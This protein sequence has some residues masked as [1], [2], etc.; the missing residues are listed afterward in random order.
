MSERVSGPLLGGALERSAHEI[1]ALV[2]RG[3]ISAEEV[4]R[5]SLDAIDADGGRLGAFL[6]VCREQALKTARDIDQRRSRGERLGPLA[7]VPIAVKD[8]LATRDAPTTAASRILLQRAAEPPDPRDGYVPPYDA[9][10][11]AKLR[12]ADAVIVGKTNMDELAMGSSNENSAFFVARNPHDPSRTPGGS[13]GGSAVAVAAKMTPLALG[14]DTGGSIR[15]PAAL[16]GIVGVKPTYGRVSRFGLF[17]FA[18]S[19]DQVGVFA[20]DV[21]GAALSL[22]VIAGGDPF[23]ATSDD[24]PAIGFD[25]GDRKGGS[26]VSRGLFRRADGRPLR[27]GVA[28]ETLE[29]GVAPGVR[30]V[31]EGSIEDLA[32]AGAEIVDVSLPSSRFAVAAYY[33][34]ATA[35]ASSNLARYDGVR[36]GLRVQEGADALDALYEKTRGRGFGREVKR[37]IILG[38]FVLSSGYY[39]AYYKRAQRVRALIRA[40]FERAFQDVDVLLSPTSPT[41]AFGLG[42]KTQDPLAMYLGDICT[43]PASLAGLPALSLPCGTAMPEDGKASRPLPVGLQLIAPAFEEPR[44]LHI[45]ADIEALFNDRGRAPTPAPQVPEAPP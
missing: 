37:R 19:L 21:R 38:T 41:V 15:Q 12:A 16:T 20:R 26:G 39:D 29:E 23:D 30:R 31:V 2:A 40:D 8:A 13:S 14:S 45:A 32:R 24:R 42:E 18:S 22:E 9:T 43:L 33:V 6:T 44:L 25:P 27:I 7:G 4:A 1:A 5:A 34:L 28:R 36:Y 17:A 35:E 3:E 10:V 11:I